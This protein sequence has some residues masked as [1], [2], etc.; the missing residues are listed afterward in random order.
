MHQY[1]NAAN[2]QIR[3]L[4][5]LR[6]LDSGQK[7]F[8]MIHTVYVFTNLKSTKQ[9]DIFLHVHIYVHAHKYLENSMEMGLMGGALG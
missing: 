1:K 6:I 7:G 2:Q 4:K 5:D 3:K 9:K 8:R